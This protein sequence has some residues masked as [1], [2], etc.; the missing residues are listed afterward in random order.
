MHFASVCC[1]TYTQ[2]QVVPKEEV[3][4]EYLSG[5]KW[6]ISLKQRRNKFIVGMW[7]QN[8]VDMYIYFFLINPSSSVS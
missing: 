6:K 3:S 1:I 2:S 5:K 7:D 8:T 4:T